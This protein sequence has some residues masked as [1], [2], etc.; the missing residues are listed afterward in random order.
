MHNHT[1]HLHGPC[2]LQA[3]SDYDRRTRIDRSQKAHQYAEGLVQE[4][5]A[6]SGSDSQADNATQHQQSPQLPPATSNK[7]PEVGGATQ[8]QQSPQ[9]PPATSNKEPEVGGATQ[10]QQSPQ[11]PP[12]TSNDEPGV[13]ESVAVVTEDSTVTRPHIWVGQC[14]KVEGDH[15]IVAPY[16][17]I[18]QSVYAFR[19]GKGREKV[20][21][22]DIVSPIDLVHNATDNTYRL[23][24]TKTEVHLC[25][26][27]LL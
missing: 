10:H 26:S 8:H 22:R 20:P 25:R 16:Q 17:E 12:A 18:G 15:A 24:T 2:P 6:T 4:A 1:H 27:P 14:L 19:V 11:L 5:L 13:G 21:L 7:E 3:L 9:L 23:R